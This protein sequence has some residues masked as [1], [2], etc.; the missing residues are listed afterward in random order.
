MTSI[1]CPLRVVPGVD[2]SVFHPSAT[3]AALSGAVTSRTA[4]RVLILRNN[5]TSHKKP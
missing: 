3:V 1:A 5:K 4:S 2:E